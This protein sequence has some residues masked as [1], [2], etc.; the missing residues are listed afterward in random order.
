MQHT[1]LDSSVKCWGP[2]KDGFRTMPKKRTAEDASEYDAADCQGTHELTPPVECLTLWDLMEPTV[3][4]HTRAIVVFFLKY[5]V[6]S[7]QPVFLAVSWALMPVPQ[8]VVRSV[9][10]HKTRFARIS[11]AENGHARSYLAMQSCAAD[12]RREDSRGCGLSD[13]GLWVESDGTSPG[14]VRGV[15]AATRQGFHPPC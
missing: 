14:R 11:I 1:S 12:Y 6:Q 2:G 5:V 7:A 13:G 15:S 3:R 8:A 4:A 9:D 10:S